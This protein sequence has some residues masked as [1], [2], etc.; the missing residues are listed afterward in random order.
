MPNSEINAFQRFRE[1]ARR[2]VDKHPVCA[3]NHESEKA[4][5]LRLGEGEDMS[6]LDAGIGSF[7]LRISSGQGLDFEPLR[8]ER[9]VERALALCDAVVAGRGVSLTG[10][11]GYPT[12]SWVFLASRG[13]KEAVTTTAV[14]ITSWR[15]ARSIRKS[16][17]RRS[18]LPVLLNESA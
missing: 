18:R 12:R 17:W 2:F 5:L 1:E 14:S 8:N 15:R 16:L 11:N 13:F 10:P 4:I 3:I 6:L 7:E 9:D